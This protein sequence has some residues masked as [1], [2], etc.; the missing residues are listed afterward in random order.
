MEWVSQLL[1]WRSTSCISR[2]RPTLTCGAHWP[3]AAREQIFTRPHETA[4]SAVQAALLGSRPKLSPSRSFA[5]AFYRPA[6]SPLR[7]LLEP[8]RGDWGR[9]WPWRRKQGLRP[10]RSSSSSAQVLSHR[11][12]HLLLHIFNFLSDAIFPDRLMFRAL[13]SWVGVSAGM[14]GSILLRNG[15]L[16]DVLGELQVDRILTPHFSV[17]FYYILCEM[18]LSSDLRFL[19]VN[20]T[21]TIEL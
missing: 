9:G 14:T 3:A 5:P 6:P 1:M 15:R 11:H 17:L 12:H 21:H 19:T 18:V 7:R 20:C 16:S 13:T 10:P 2:N 8:S 4:R